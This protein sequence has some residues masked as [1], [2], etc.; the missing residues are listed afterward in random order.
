MP[1]NY[2]EHLSQDTK[3]QKREKKIYEPPRIEPLGELARATGLCGAGS[4]YGG[5]DCS[6]GFKAD[7]QC[8]VGTDIGAAF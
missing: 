1:E 2:K 7:I 4:G 6:S 5:G 8:S 3:P